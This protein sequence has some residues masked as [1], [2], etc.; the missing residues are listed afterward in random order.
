[1]RHIRS[2][3]EVPIDAVSAVGAHNRAIVRG[4]VFRYD[5]PNVAVPRAGLDCEREKAQIDDQSL[6]HAHI[7]ISLLISIDFSRHS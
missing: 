7:A 3:V 1:M 5:V 2:A 6:S 4:R